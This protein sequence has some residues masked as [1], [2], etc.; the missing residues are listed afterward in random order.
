MIIS[1]RYENVLDCIAVTLPKLE[2]PDNT[3]QRQRVVIAVIWLRCFNVT[4]TPGGKEDS[5]SAVRRSLQSHQH[6]FPARNRRDQLT[7]F[8][9]VVVTLGVTREVFT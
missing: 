4:D 6:V 7:T 2:T 3:M 9:C 8:H 5:A 1:Q